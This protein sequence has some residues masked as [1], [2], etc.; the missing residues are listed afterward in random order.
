MAAQDISLASSRETL[1][2]QV[3]G[4]RQLLLL[5]GIAAAVAAGIWVVMWSQDDV[6]SALFTNLADRDAMEI[7]QVLDASGIPH[8]YESGVVMVPSDQ[9]HA[10]RLQLASQSL[11]NSAGVGFEMLNESNGISDSQFIETAR[12]QRALEVE[13]QRTI[14]SIN[15][16]GSARVHLAVP[17]QTVF[18]RKRTQPGASVLVNL[19]PGRLLEPAQVASIVNLVASSVTDMERSQVT[20]VDQNGNLLSVDPDAE[21]KGDRNSSAVERQGQRMEERLKLRIEE[22]LAPIVGRENALAQVAVSLNPETLEETQE[23]YDPDSQVVRSEQNSADP[24]TGLQAARGIPGALSNLPPVAPP[25]AAEGGQP[26]PDE[27]A[28]DPPLSTRSLRNYEIGRTV[29]YIQAP[30]G[31]IRRLNVAVV[32]N[33]RT[34]LNDDGDVESVP[35]AAEELADLTELVRKAVGFEEARGDAV[36]VIGADF[37]LQPEREQLDLPEPSFLDQFNLMESLRILA[38]VIV[39]LLL[40]FT[41]IRPT[42]RQLLTLPPRTVMLPSAVPRGLPPGQDGEGAPGDGGGSAGGGRP[43]SSASS[44]NQAFDEQVATA[45]AMVNQDPERVAQVVRNWVNEGE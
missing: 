2:D 3:P 5:V 42:L 31:S 39:V 26:Q 21:D 30:M 11:P 6:Y 35:Y 17:R 12:Y 22:L 24:T 8:R 1:I 15:A 20:V 18:V 16:I 14:A 19:Y 40:V 29:R 13:L 10:A 23:L 36:A 41:I 7:V 45:K 27:N 32:L 9:V 4:L 25:A 28:D 43:V 44:V 34:R 33:Q 37:L 38:A